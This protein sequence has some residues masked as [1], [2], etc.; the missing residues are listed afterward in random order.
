MPAFQ[1]KCVLVELTKVF[2]NKILIPDIFRS[3]DFNKDKKI[4][5]G[6]KGHF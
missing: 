5:I 6:S 2:T 4:L 3:Q 1:S